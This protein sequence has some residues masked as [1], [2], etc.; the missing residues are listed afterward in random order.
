MA[1]DLHNTRDQATAFAAQHVAALASEV[2]DWQDTG[3]LSGGVLRELAEIVAPIAGD[4]KMQMAESFANRAARLALTA[5]VATEQAQAVAAGW[6]FVPV[7]PTEEMMAAASE[8]REHCRRAGRIALAS[9]IYRA[10]LAASPEAAPAAMEVTGPAMQLN[11]TQ[12]RSALELA[13]PDFD[14]DEDQREVEV[15]LQRLPARTSS[16]GEPMEAGLYCWLAEYPEEGCIPLR[17]DESFPAATPAA[18]SDAET[19]ISR[20]S[21]AL[22][23]WRVEGSPFADVESSEK[24]LRAALAQPAPVQADAQQARE[25][26]T[27]GKRS[28]AGFMYRHAVDIASREKHANGWVQGPWQLT[29][30]I[31]GA[32]RHPHSGVWPGFEFYPLYRDLSDEARTD[33]ALASREEAHAAPV[34]QDA[35][36]PSMVGDAKGGA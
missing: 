8:E 32:K 3:V 11:A 36:A 26:E 25:Q 19:L 14:T 23:G 9:N 20:Y 34:Q 28:L 35:P 21:N 17:E 24:A 16:D 12:L 29:F 33:T 7:E 22:I 1:N 10:M 31:E 18:P 13:A 30:D 15:V 27:R 2:N 4:H 5:P 6:K